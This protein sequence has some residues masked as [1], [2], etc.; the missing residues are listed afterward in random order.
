MP[1]EL[2][3]F[4]PRS[5]VVCAIGGGG[6]VI[7]A[8]A[9]SVWL[10]SMGV[11]TTLAAIAWERYV[12]DPCPGPLRFEHLDGVAAGVESVA[13]LGSCRAVR[14]C[15]CRGGVFIPQVCRVS[16]ILSRPVY[17]VNAWGG[18]EGIARSLIE[19]SSI[20]GAEA[21][22]GVDVGGDVL[23]EGY[24][25]NLWS[26]LADS[27]SLAGMVG[28]G[29]PGVVGVQSPGADGELPIGYM[30]ERLSDVAADG[31]LRAARMLTGLEARVIEE[32]VAG[33]AVT[34]ASLLQVLARRGV[35]GVVMLRGGA[36]RAW[37]SI[38]QT[39][40]FYL[41]AY[42]LSK[43]S[44]L[45]RLVARTT[46]LDEAVMRLNEAGVY[47][48][49][50]LEEDM[51]RRACLGEAPDPRRVRREGRSRLLASFRDAGDE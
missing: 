30:L 38:L 37:L 18:A 21:I 20:T 40:I 3:G 23:G 34:E 14:L 11:R 33:G 7:S 35:R 44:P 27:L 36:R 8:A 43:L 45:Y 41:D 50:N 2:F 10:E 9:H 12:V 32:L 47:T 13:A 19:V 51:A 28:S 48:E 24:E 6:D 15:G 22:L 29:L 42:S 1:E 17:I 25:A 4:K 5:V 31:G 16:R 49:Y 39:L 46:S 26:P